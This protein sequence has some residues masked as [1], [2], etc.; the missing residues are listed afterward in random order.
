MPREQIGQG[1][2]AFPGDAEDLGC[3]HNQAF[4]GGDHRREYHETIEGIV[5]NA[6]G[7]LH[8]QFG[9]LAVAAVV[10]VVR[11][12]RALFALVK[13]GGDGFRKMA[14]GEKADTLGRCDG[15]GRFHQGEQGVHFFREAKRKAFFFKDTQRIVRGLGPVICEEPF[16]ERLGDHRLYARIAVRGVPENGGEDVFK[17]HV[18]RH[19]EIKRGEIALLGPDGATSEAMGLRGRKKGIFGF[20]LFLL[21]QRIDAVRNTLVS[22]DADVFRLMHI[23]K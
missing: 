20:V 8:R 19:D 3:L 21:R 1:Q 13:P 18:R 5:S 22:N 12:Q 14:E 17:N 11:E 2:Y 15:Q 6:G 23:I 10:V 7:G 9:G 4:H 16:A